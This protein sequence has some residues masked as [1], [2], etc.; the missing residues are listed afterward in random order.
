MKKIFIYSCVYLNFFSLN[1]M[2]RP[3]KF[4]GNVAKIDLREE[5]AFGLPV[6]GKERSEQMKENKQRADEAF[7]AS[8]NEVRDVFRQEMQEVFHTN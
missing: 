6:V 3:S 1:S 4:S 2:Q 5:S 7:V 8:L